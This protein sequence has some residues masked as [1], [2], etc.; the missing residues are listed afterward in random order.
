MAIDGV[1]MAWIESLDRSPDGC[2]AGI[3]KELAARWLVFRSVGRHADDDRPLDPVPT[4][5]SK[6]PAVGLG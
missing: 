2:C 4:A 1:L 6:T 5:V 3:R